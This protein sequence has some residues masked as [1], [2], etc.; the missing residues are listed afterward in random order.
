MKP[1]YTALAFITFSAVSIIFLFG[2]PIPILWANIAVYLVVSTAFT[3]AWLKVCADS[4]AK[5]DSYI[6]KSKED[7]KRFGYE[8][9]V[10]TS[11]VASV[12]EQ[13]Y[14]TLD[15]NN[16]FA[17]QLYAEAVEMAALNNDVNQNIHSI[18]G[19]MKNIIGLLEEGCKA[20]SEM[21][22]KSNSSSL[23]IHESINEIMEIVSTINEIQESSSRTAEYMDR[24]NITSKEIVHILE[25]VS[26]ISQQT[27][28]LALNASI[29]SAR[30]G[31]AGK[32]FAVVADEIRKL[33]QRTGVAVKEI[34]VLIGCIQ[35]EIGDVFK[36]VQYNK[37]SVE[38]GVK[39]T[40]NIED[41]LRKIG[42]SFGLINGL[43]S[44]INM[45]SEKEIYMA[46]EAE[47]KIEIVE[48]AVCIN[49]ST[50]EAVKQSIH[51]QKHTV[52]EIADLGTRLSEA[53]KSMSGLFDQSSP[54]SFMLDED[55]IKRKAHEIFDVLKTECL[56]DKGILT[57]DVS[58]HCALLKGIIEKCDNIEAAWTNGIRGR[59]ICSIP[60]A[61]IANACVREWFKE[62]VKGTEYIS[63]VYISAITRNPCVTL[64]LP[65]RDGD[66]SIIGV[67]GV[68]LKI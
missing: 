66:G 48:C 64:S 4:T 29:E 54:S 3:G 9:Q 14:V 7:T 40:K 24:L 35:N 2:R 30:A 18:I 34:G 22:A 47:S 63:P 45:L 31:E 26:T 32:G 11:Q 12:A 16:A 53:S 55:T 68:D 36:A 43:V 17:Q 67:L 28:L 20:S 37:N 46:R 10:S 58:H 57:M 5:S 21:E 27:H 38:N 52:E 8:V 33:S 25:A 51:R 65:I 1:H 59:F 60:E 42:T 62:S 50:V 6:K 41:N 23:V 61:G 13:L 56:A 49:A 19:S 39:A 44:K 15:E